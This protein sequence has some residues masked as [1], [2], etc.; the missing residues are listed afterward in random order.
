MSDVIEEGYWKDVPMMP[1]HMK[2]SPMKTNRKFL[3]FDSQPEIVGRD[4]DLEELKRL[5]EE[6]SAGRGNL[7]FLSGEAGIGKTRILDEVKNVAKSRGFQV[8]SGNST[9]ESLT[10]YM[11]FL[12]ALRSGDLSSLFA[13][14]APR[15]EAVF[16]VTDTGLL[17][18]EVLR[19]ETEID[20][21][22]FAS[23]LTT[24]SNFVKESLSMLKGD[25][26]LDTLNRLGYGEYTILIESGVNTNLVV[27]ITGEENEF[28]INDMR[29]ILL[30]VHRQYGNIL[31]RW[32]GDEKKVEGIGN[33]LRPLITSGKYDGIYYGKNNPRTRRNLLFENVSLGLMRQAQTRPVLLCLEDLQWADP[34]TLALTH[35]VARNARKCGL[36]IL[37]T[38]RP[39]DL[40]TKEGKPHPLVETMHLMNRED[41]YQKIDLGR[42]PK[43]SMDEFLASLLGKTD[44]S[45]DFRDRIYR[46]TEGNPLFVVELIRLLVE[47]EIIKSFRGVWKLAKDLQEV[48]IP[49]KIHDVVVRRLNW[50]EKEDRKVLD[51]ASVLGEVFTSDILADALKVERIYLLERLRILEQTHNLIH[52]IDGK[53]VFDH[54]KIKEVVYSEIPKE[55]RREYHAV[56]ADSLESLFK[57]S[58]DEALG[59]LAFH[60]YQCK[61]KEKALFYKIKTAEKARKDYSNEEATRFYTEAL[62]FE[63]DPQKR[64]EIFENLGAIYLLMGDCEKSIE[65]YESALEL[66]EDKKEMAEVKTRIG[67]AHEKKGEY[68]ESIRICNEGLEMV[69][70]EECEEE[71]FALSHIGTVYFCKGEYDR[72]LRYLEEGLRI[73]KRIDDKSGIASS[74]NNIGNVYLRRGECDKALEHYERSLEIRKE[75]GNLQDIARSQGNIGTLHLHMGEYD[76]AL[77]Q[78][79]NSLQT[80]EKI[81]DQQ[82]IGYTLNN[83]GVLYEERGEYDRALEHYEKSSRIVEKIGDQQVMVASLHNIGIVNFYREEYDRALEHFERS[84]RISTRIGYQVG[85]A[86]NY[87]GMA[88]VH[89]KK[90]D[91]VKALKFCK[92]ASDLSK[93]I[94]L[95]QYVGAAKR[96]FGM[97]F[98]ERKEWDKSI[99]NFEE[100]IDIYREIGMEKELGES[101]LEFGMMWKK[102]GNLDR[103]KKDLSSALAIFEGLDLKRELGRVREEL[104]ALG[105]IEKDRR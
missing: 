21:D 3:E 45:E 66:C 59:D 20:S 24:V 28:L 67:I 4:K 26:V 58:L 65:S 63:E 85:I 62:E 104:A 98:R 84:L 43:A 55:L 69:R 95:K 22:L 42:L 33:L 13:E 71:A 72:A 96:I 5:L 16:L 11:P 9:Y 19:E 101:L 12:E 68:E 103:A 18:E 87:C 32:D 86:Y 23:M 93:E 31:E 54:A 41:L 64:M 39:E 60:Y 102:K 97:V 105:E 37:G 27:I 74:F 53:Y 83:I 81:G 52:S 70:G 51:Y 10:P 80:L 92:Q 36:L 17:V 79:E 25:E 88:E 100:S 50:V 29:E 75:L 14:E 77:E 56:I 89:F 61:N 1:N 15:V 8:L 76:H 46:E 57:D 91:F 99:G 90:G 82:G 47:E 35:Y 44:F 34:S 38:Y 73:R 7:I 48:N 6:A 30:R 49:S 40:T 94:G 78:F 2:R